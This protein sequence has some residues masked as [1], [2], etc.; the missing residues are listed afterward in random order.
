MG[1]I[2][3]IDK[4]CSTH[5]QV[6]IPLHKDEIFLMKETAKLRKIPFNHYVRELIT[7]RLKETMPRFL[8][9]DEK[10]W[11]PSQEDVKKFI[12]WLSRQ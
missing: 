5:R 7:A 1:S 4:L 10:C 12:D 8:Y 2:N 3:K 11:P 6:N 9:P